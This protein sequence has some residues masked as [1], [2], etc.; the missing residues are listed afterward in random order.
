MIRIGISRVRD[1]AVAAFAAHGPGKA[2]SVKDGTGVCDIA[3]EPP[4]QP[5]NRAAPRSANPTTRAKGGKARTVR[6]PRR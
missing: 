5:L 4:E 1:G 2:G 3:R 6:D